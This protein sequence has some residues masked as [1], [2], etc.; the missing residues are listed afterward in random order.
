MRMSLLG[1]SNRLRTETEVVVMEAMN[2][3][4]NSVTADNIFTLILSNESPLFREVVF[5]PMYE[6]DGGN[7]KVGQFESLVVPFNRENSLGFPMHLL[8]SD[9]VGGVSEQHRGLPFSCGGVTH[10]RKI[11]WLGKARL[12]EE[13]QL[14]N[15]LVAADV[16]LCSWTGAAVRPHRGLHDRLVG[17]CVVRS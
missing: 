2:R 16:V 8:H 6:W 9:T 14:G 15:V 11:R 12:T 10:R 5:R 3:A 17:T 13:G 7:T 4:T 1:S